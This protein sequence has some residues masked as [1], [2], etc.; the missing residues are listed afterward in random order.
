MRT[1]RS[2]S[3]AIAVALTS[4]VIAGCAT[5]PTPSAVAR[6]DPTA[7][8][9]TDIRGGS[10][11]SR[12][13]SPPLASPGTPD[14]VLGP[15]VLEANTTS[16]RV[17]SVTAGS[18][19]CAI[20]TDDQLRC[21]GG[22][23]R[24][25]RPP[26]GRYAF[27]DPGPDD[28]CA[29]RSD[30]T[31]VCWGP[32]AEEPPE[33][34]FTAVAAASGERCAIRIGGSLAC[35]RI[36]YGEALPEDEMP[37]SALPTG[38]F[39]QLAM[40]DLGASCGLRTDGSV[41][42]WPLGEPPVEVAGGP[43][44]SLG[45]GCAVDD[46]GALV[47]FAGSDLPAAP[48]PEGDFASMSGSPQVGC[49]LRATGTLACWGRQGFDRATDEELPMRTPPGTYTAVSVDESR[50]CAIGTDGRAVCWGERDDELRP[51]PSADVNAP[52]LVDRPAIDVTWQA[53]PFTAPITGVDVDYF[54]RRWG[55][56]GF[57]DASGQDPGWTP[58]L[59]N[60]SEASA[61]L[62]A[63]TGGTFCFRARAHDADG[64]TGSWHE[65]G[66]TAVPLD[67]RELGATADWTAVEG[68]EYF[69]GTALRTTTKGAVLRIADDGPGSI[70]IMA[71]QCAGCGT[72]VLT[73]VGHD[74][75]D[76]TGQAAPTCPPAQEEVDLKGSRSD[77]SLVLASNNGDEGFAGPIQIVVTS[78]GKPVIIDAV[79]FNLETE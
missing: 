73:S 47:C 14:A 7:G 53:I 31:L 27:V 67:D 51:G 10:L 74:C 36:D 45:D 48:L 17:R 25:D 69:L 28:T 24:V 71:T 77:S 29:I 59:A 57:P 49:A 70:R 55:P 20:G 39:T 37:R 32:F 43:F 63:P 19:I 9:T 65:G 26:A 62:S 18:S 30:R 8:A 22:M 44:V 12:V 35:W 2:R 46:N 75:E 38:T 6:G 50:A 78:S 64:L 1:R 72:F 23:S 33:G 11:P 5:G 58:W 76:G 21:W 66:C 61:T 42:C 15:D 3:I 79:I 4:L 68:N 41:A 34:E 56:G 60:T 13:P 54:V 16:W 40:S 52:P